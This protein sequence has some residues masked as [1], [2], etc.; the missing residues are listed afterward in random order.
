MT[1]DD[2]APGA[3][4]NIWVPPTEWEKGVQEIE[5]TSRARQLEDGRLMSESRLTLSPEW[6]GELFHGYR[7]AACLER[8]I[9]AFPEVCRAPW[10]NFPIRD[11]QRRQLRMDFVGEQPTPA[12]G[13]DLER[14]LAYL[15]M[16]RHVPKPRTH[17]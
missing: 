13:F 10:C 5:P 6:M 12:V 15:E 11:E 4:N 1:F 7:C 9:E 8:Q 3:R 14:E 2:D 17:H 16:V